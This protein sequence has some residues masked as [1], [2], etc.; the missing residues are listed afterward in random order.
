[1][2]F[3]IRPAMVYLISCR[4]CILQSLLR[5]FLAPTLH[6]KRYT[7]YGRHFTKAEKLR[8]VRVIWAEGFIVIVYGRECA[9]ER[10]TGRVTFWLCRWW[11]FLNLTFGMET[12]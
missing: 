9:L 2:N 7:S 5:T 1:M 10:L 8:R 6:G 11:K 3:A 12:R 4:A